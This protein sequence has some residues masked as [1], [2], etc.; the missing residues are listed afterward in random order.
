MNLIFDIAL[1]HV[2]S[3]V[4]QTGFAVAGVATGVGFSIMMAS[5][6]QGSQDDFTHRL[7]NTL[8]HITV[9]D[10]RRTPP[11]Q[12]AE[13]LFEAAEIHG[14]TPEA[15]RPGIKNPLAI[16]AALEAWMPG[17]VAPSAKVQA[18]IRYAN[19]D[20]A[21][22][23]TGIDP[24]RES[25]VSE[26]PQQMR[27]ATLIA[28]YR[29][30]NAIVIGDRLSEK[31]GAR[32][33]AN[34]TLQTSQGA[35]ITAQ[36]V[37]FFH[38]GVRQQD[39]GTAYVL[40]KTGQILAQQTGLI[41]ELH[42][43]LADP[44]Q[45]REIAARVERDTGYKSVSW[46]EAYE[47]L[48]STFIIRNIIMYAVVGAILLVASFGTY[49]IISTIT[50][51]KSRDIAI[52]KSLG[53]REFTVRMIFVT[54]ALII[55]LVGALAGFTLGYLLC[56]GLGSIRITNPFIDSNY[57]PL[58]YTYVHYLMA[59]MVALVSSVIAGYQPARKAA[60]GNPVEIIRGAT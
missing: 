10:E 15:R 60:R 14:L 56:V 32:I 46:Q 27:G 45:A 18:I 23:V 3:R 53:L 8:P 21:T 1:T 4:R 59:G 58:A 40:T 11:Q 42:I 17:G 28:L 7:I 16:M 29:A 13:V 48:L 9:T 43:R 51:E 31:I 49:N 57:L 44:L 5:L 34:I 54:E 52:M 47:D 38:T 30:T 24:R 55:G 19:H 6:M 2:R 26:L 37:G 36:V 12:P 33:G 41:N 35:R 22:T 39:E 25:K 20:V 50:H